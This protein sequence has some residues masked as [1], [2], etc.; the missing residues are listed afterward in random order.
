[1]QSV[2]PNYSIKFTLVG[3]TKAVS[4]IKF[5][6]DGQ[7]LASSA[8]DKSIKIWG[9]YD[10]NFERTILGHKLVSGSPL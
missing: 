7:W 9:A 10:G 5:S 4:S 2:R 6:Q 1:M 8:A 3:H